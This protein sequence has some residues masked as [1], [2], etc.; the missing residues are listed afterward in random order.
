MVII[1]GCMVC[2]LS[3]LLVKVLL[4]VHH[5]R[6]QVSVK[7]A[8]RQNFTITTDIR[9][10]LFN[11]L[12][13]EINILYDSMKDAER[14][15]AT[16]E[17][18]FKTMLSNIA[19]DV[20]TPLTS[21][22]G[23][24]QLLQQTDDEQKN[25]A[26]T[27]IIDQRIND[28]KRLLEEFFLYSKLLHEDFM[29]ETRKIALYP[30]LCE[31]L[32]S[33]YPMFEAEHTEPILSFEDTNMMVEANPDLLKRVLQNLIINSL[34]HGNGNL[35]IT[36]RGNA[37]C[38]SNPVASDISIDMEQV[39]QRFYKGDTS[40]TK[41]SSG[42]GLTIVKRLMELSEGSVR[43]ELQNNHFMIQLIFSQNQ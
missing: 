34:W 12:C 7:I 35:S 24:L 11:L 31:I 9:V 6:Q 39:F 13:D 14:E 5:I 8:K 36:Q 28:V 18:E 27:S 19:H 23:Y 40:R 1:L 29:P 42:L 26:Y 32:A 25:K 33:Y 37:V 10:N 16:K 30:C 4:E 38:F 2:I 43:A 22:Q 15:C 41:T 3:F 17:K 20:R 21:V